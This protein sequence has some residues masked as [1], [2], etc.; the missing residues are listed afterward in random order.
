MDLQD[1]GDI[2][3]LVRCHGVPDFEAQNFSWALLKTLSRNDK[4]FESLS[5]LIHDDCG[6]S[7]LGD[8]W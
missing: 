1:Q 7:G 8:S 5:S 3:W 2:D 6:Q 4:P